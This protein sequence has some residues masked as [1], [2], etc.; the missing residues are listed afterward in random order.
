MLY[1]AA[2]QVHAVAED[3]R[4]LISYL[5][6]SMQRHGVN[7]LQMAEHVGVHYST[8]IRW[9]K[10]DDVPSLTSCRKIASYL[11]IPEDYVL[12]LA[13]HKKATGQAP[14]EIADPLV[15]LMM[16][17][18]K[19]LTPEER[20]SVERFVRFVLAEKARM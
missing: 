12:E 19:I 1:N 2:R 14:L 18:V 5:T 20:R 13:G 9:L 8:A 7:K 10:G 15:Q 3:H 6:Q 17:A 4:P 11:K 16:E